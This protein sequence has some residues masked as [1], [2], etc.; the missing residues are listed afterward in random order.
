ML[1]YRHYAR[2][3]VPVC[4]DALCRAPL[5]AFR[6]SLGHGEGLPGLSL[7]PLDA[8]HLSL[9]D[10]EGGHPL[11]PSHDSLGRAFG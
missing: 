7:P 4:V 11:R 1:R 9:R 2:I 6:G 8:P 5:R 3:A 10:I